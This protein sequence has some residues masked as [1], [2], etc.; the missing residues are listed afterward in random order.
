MPRTPFLPSLHAFRF[1]NRWADTGVVKVNFGPLGRIPLGSAI[2]GLCVGMTWANLDLF[3]SGRFPPSLTTTPTHDGAYSSVYDYIA[4]RQ[5]ESMNYVGSTE[6][7]RLLNLASVGLQWFLSL[8]QSVPTATKFESSRTREWPKVRE[9]LDGGRPIPLVLLRGMGQTVKEMQSNHSVLVYD[10]AESAT[11]VQLSVYDPNY[12]LRDDIRLWWDKAPQAQP[13]LGYTVPLSRVTYGFT[14]STYQPKTPP[15]WPQW[16]EEARQN[17]VQASGV[18]QT[19]LTW[20]VVG[21]VAYLLR[22]AGKL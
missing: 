10:Y 5:M 17:P 1:P 22:R 2:N 4:K 11:Q 14:A 13:R 15:Q 20:S 21:T 3:L 6:A 8:D 18:G 7:E 9:A 12:P 19:W 16:P